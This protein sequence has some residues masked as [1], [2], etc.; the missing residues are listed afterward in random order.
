MSEIKYLHPGTMLAGTLSERAIP[1]GRFAAAL[2]VPEDTLLAVL[3][4]KKEISLSWSVAI[5]KAL[6]GNSG[7]RW[8]QLQE[9][10][11][12]WKNSQLRH[13]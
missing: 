4:G 7:L 10:Y 5:N 6:E 12:Q 3:E 2:G 9:D 8:R 11:D 13:K 1:V